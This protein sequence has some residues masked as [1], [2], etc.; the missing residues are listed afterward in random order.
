[1]SPNAASSNLQRFVQAQDSIYTSVLAELRGGRK[2]SHWMW[3][4]FPQIAG[5]GFSST[6]QHYA[7]K[8][9]EEARQYLQHPILG[10]RLL[11]CCQTVLEIS[12]HS[13]HDIFGSPDDLKLKSSMTLFE[14]VA[15]PNAPFAAVLERYFQG[16]RDSKTLAILK[17][18]ASAGN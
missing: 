6:S 12:G 17:Q 1:M 18:L 5:L 16:Q 15:A 4:I 8:S 2:R 7:I 9:A 13:A 11:E 10:P 3:F 14:T